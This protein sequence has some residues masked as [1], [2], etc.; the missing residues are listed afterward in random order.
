[1]AKDISTTEGASIV[2]W[3]KTKANS[4][5]DR[6]ECWDAAEA[7]IKTVG[8]RR[9]GTQLYVWGRVVTPASLQLGDIIQFSGFKVHILKEDGSWQELTFGIPRHT[10]IVS[11]LNTDGSVDVMHQNYDDVRSIQTLEWVYLK[12]GTYGT[13]KVTVKGGT[14]ACYR[15]TKP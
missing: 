11:Y 4:K 2:T 5:I 1:M 10:A 8:A 14:V 3:L 12:S 6:G 13:T 15:P 7:A 9:P